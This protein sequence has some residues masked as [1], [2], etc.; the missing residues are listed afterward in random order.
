[1]AFRVGIIGGG[2]IARAHGRAA[3]N[4]AAADLVAVCD[5]SAEAAASFGDEFGVEQRYTDIDEMLDRAGVDLAIICTWGCFH[6]EISNKVARSGKVKA[7]LCEKPF[8]DT[9]AQAESR[10]QARQAEFVAARDEQR[11][12]LNDARRR[13]QAAEAEADALRDYIIRG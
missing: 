7:I 9:A 1:M 10:L 8:C 6:A 2:G 5:V 12:L 13:R 4:V 11:A 3:Q